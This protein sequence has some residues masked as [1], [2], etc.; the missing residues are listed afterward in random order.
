VD[1]D[2]LYF[3]VA[4][5]VA[6]KEGVFI[7]Q[8]ITRNSYGLYKRETG[9]RA[10][11]YAGFGMAKPNPTPLAVLPVKWPRPRQTALYRNGL[12]KVCRHL[13]KKDIKAAKNRLIGAIGK[14]L[15]ACEVIRKG[16]TYDDLGPE[17]RLCTVTA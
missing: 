14:Y 7:T 17:R 13:K 5:A 16:E 12:P 3:S 10:I 15:E 4:L 11:W 9:F 6:L 8:E 1:Y 2:G